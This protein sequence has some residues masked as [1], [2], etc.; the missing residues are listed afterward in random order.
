MEKDKFNKFFITTAIDYTNDVIHIGH[1]YQKILA[2]AIARYYRLY[3]GT[4]NTLFLTGTD[5]HGSTNEKAAATAGQTPQDFVDKISQ[6]D[7]DQLDVLQ[8]SYDRFIRTTDEDHKKQASDFY[9]KSF[10][11]GDIY[12]GKYEGLY[13]DGCESYKTFSELN[14]EGQCLLHP[15]K[16]IQTTEEENYFFKWSNYSNFLLE[17]LN[18]D[19]FVLPDGKRKEMISFV[20]QGLKDLPVSRP[21]Y[22][23]SWGIDVPNDPTHVLY[24]WFDALVNYFTEGFAKGFWTEDT[25]IVHV[26]GKD[27]ARW[28]ALLWPAMLKSAGYKVPDTIYVHGFINLDG[29]KI[30]KSRG[31]VIRPSDLVKEFGVDAV[32]YYFLK[33]GPITEDVDISVTNLKEVYNADLANGLGNSVARVAKLAERSGFEFPLDTKDIPFGGDIF[34][35]LRDNYRVDLTLANIWKELSNLDKHINENEPWG[36]KD[37]EKL[38]EVLGYEVNEIRKIS[39]LIEPFIPNTAKNIHDQFGDL[40]IKSATGLFPRI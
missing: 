38:K 36:I 8:V 24:V 37:D 13:C 21:K 40:K 7:K 26:L 4:D 34:Q 10:Q 12:K 32:R 14:E 39:K 31:N 20:E 15:T 9:N 29:Q 5:E 16:K 18:R 11:N 3:I 19:S 33:F 6:L 28:H 1:A 17:L 27:N 22:K 2:D 25:K 30:S 35:P 23:V